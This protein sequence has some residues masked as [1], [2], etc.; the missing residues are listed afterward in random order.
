[1]TAQDPALPWELLLHHVIPYLCERG[2]LAAVMALA[3]TCKD[4]YEERVPWRSHVTSLEISGPRYIP[5]AELA[6]FANSLRHLDYTMSCHHA[7][8]YEADLAVCTQLVS[9][10]LR[11]N[12]C[13]TYSYEHHLP[14]SVQ[15]LELD[16]RVPNTIR[17]CQDI[18]AMTTLHQV[19]FH[20]TNRFYSKY[21]DRGVVDKLF[22][23]RIKCHY[24][25]PNHISLEPPLP[26]WL[27]ERIDALEMSVCQC[28]RHERKPHA[29]ETYRDRE[30]VE[31]SSS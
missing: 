7:T 9:L 12:E 29:C 14:A 2:H 16:D 11:G 18:N 10:R 3:R 8:C 13:G 25:D 24:L 5:T 23:T 19:V 6:R 1:M 28:F 31:L 15:M 4:L 21:E 20:V 26:R 30:D 17:I 22:I 27:E